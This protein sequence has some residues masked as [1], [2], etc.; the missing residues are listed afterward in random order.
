VNPELPDSAFEFKP[1][2]GVKVIH[3]QK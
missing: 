3:P 2:A 1:P